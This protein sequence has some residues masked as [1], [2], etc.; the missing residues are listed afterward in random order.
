MRESDCMFANNLCII[1]NFRHKRD[2]DMVWD[3]EPNIYKA[4]PN[5]AQEL[6]TECGINI[7][8]VRAEI[9]H[10]EEEIRNMTTYSQVKFK[11]ARDALK[12]VEGQEKEVEELRYAYWGKSLLVK[13]VFHTI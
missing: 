6:K 8:Q 3:T 2:P 11:E 7:D 10:L 12:K 9:P 13:K 5:L 4:P 1:D